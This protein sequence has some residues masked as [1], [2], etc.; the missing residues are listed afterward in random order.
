MNR[1][2]RLE[3]LISNEEKGTGYKM[4]EI[5]WTEKYRPKD[6]CDVIGLPVQLEDQDLNN[7]THLLMIGKPGIGKT[8]CARIIADKLEADFLELNAS[9]DRGIAV[10]RQKVKIFARKASFGR[11]VILL[12]ESDGITPDAQNSLRSIM[13]SCSKSTLFILTANY[14][15]KIIEP[16]RSRCI[17]IE[18]PNPEKECIIERLGKIC[19]KEGYS[20]EKDDLKFITGLT[21]PDIRKAINMLQNACK[22]G[23]VNIKDIQVGT[24]ILDAIWQLINEKD[25]NT[26]RILLGTYTPDL[27]QV[28]SFLFDKVCDVDLP[29]SDQYNALIKIAE[30]AYRNQIV[31]QPDINFIACSIELIR[32]IQ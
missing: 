27:D 9:D 20:Y 11:K 31:A 4:K 18:F 22:D 24:D 28:Y 17:V 30:Y 26:M 12:D 23:K 19:D 6:F 32:L 3:I 21:Y 25:L 2:P 15:K 5:H 14:L 1:I 8:T 10:I 13:E 29:R 16:I 7:L